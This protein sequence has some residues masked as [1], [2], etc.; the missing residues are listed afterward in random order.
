MFS[1]G[2]S[3]VMIARSRI[4]ENEGR[5]GICLVLPFSQIDI[6]GGGILSDGTSAMSLLFSKVSGNKAL[7]V[8]GGIAA[9]ESAS[10]SIEG[11][12]FADN[13]ALQISTIFGFNND[14]SAL[15]KI[16]NTTT[17]ASQGV[18]ALMLGRVEMG[19]QNDWSCSWPGSVFTEVFA[20]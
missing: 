18:L 2:G 17:I 14:N 10:F 11:C 6:A 7:S 13:S 1:G 9:T 8:G 4:I 19:E 3:K 12:E 20:Q 16:V 15:F 5:G